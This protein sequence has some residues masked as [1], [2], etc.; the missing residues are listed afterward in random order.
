[1]ELNWA[2]NY[3]YAGAISYPP[4]LRQ[5]QELTASSRRIRA[6]GSRH[7]FN[8]IADTSGPLVVLDQLA[9]PIE[10]DAASGSVTVSGAA[11]YGFVATELARHGLALHN[12]ASLPHI[13]IAGAIATGT[14]GSGDRN[15]SLA[16]AVSALELVTASGELLTVTRQSTANFA[17]MVVA[18]GAL[19]I[20]TRVTLDIQPTFDVR[21]DVFE[22]L[23][24]QDVLDN[25]DDIMSS[26]YS[27]SLFTDWSGPA[28]SQAWLKSRMD[29]AP[30]DWSQG[31]F[32]GRPATAGRHPLPGI[33]SVNCT[34][35]LGVPGVWADRL[36]HFEMAFTPSSGAELQ[37][38]YHVPRESA[39]QAIE[40]MRELSAQIT[41][42]LLVSEIR[43]VAADD[44]WLSPSYHRAGVAL[45]FTWKPHQSGVEALLPVLEE[46]LQPFFTRPHWGKLFHADAAALSGRYERF[47]DFRSLAARMD[48]EH[49]FRNEF[50]DRVVFGS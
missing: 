9:T 12:L 50:L 46:A 20:V 37:S 44:L 21:Q 24:W 4:T 43:S 19:G 25:F 34:Q 35:Q 1:M 39:P 32:G 22:Q 48:P 26:A 6:L 40:A 5:L 38:E 2:G 17:G 14:H 15:G 7:S 41:P 47:D 23:P 36:P 42:L 13:S 3:E 11:T 16:T 27:V 45:H 30:V 8:D 49:K 18:L 29:G 31:F 28:L 33:S 10:I